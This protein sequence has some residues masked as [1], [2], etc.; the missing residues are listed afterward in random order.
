MKADL[1]MYSASFKQEVQQIVA[2]EALFCRHVEKG[3]FQAINFAF[4]SYFPETDNE[5]RSITVER[6][7]E[8]PTP[9][10]LACTIVS[11]RDALA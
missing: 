2:K 1:V 10:A 11:L 5:R 6:S 9:V 7:V 8:L 3:I 4:L